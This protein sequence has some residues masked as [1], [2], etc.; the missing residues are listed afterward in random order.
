MAKKG[1]DRKI[2][3]GKSKK[4]SILGLVLPRFDDMFR[5]FY[6]S[7]V[8]RGVCNAA[9][10]AGVDIL[11]HLTKKI[12]SERSITTHFENISSCNGVI[13]ADIK[14]NEKLLNKTI[15]SGIP[16]VVINH[17][18][19]NLKAGCVAINNKAGAVNAVDYMLSLGHQ[20]I[21][22]ITGDLDIQAGRD[23]LEGYKESLNKHSIKIDK[24]L[25][26]ESDF[27]PVK[28]REKTAELIRS[29][30][31]PTAIF[32]GS[33]EIACEVVRTLKRSK[34]KVPHDISVVGF[35]NSWFATQGP[36]ALTTVKQPLSAMGERAVR[37]LE[38]MITSGGKKGATKAILPTELVVRD[39]CV[40]PLRQQDFY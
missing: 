13:F 11:V 4:I 33:D 17:Y 29:S 16:C 25:I 26:I 19:K 7:E 40:P 10:A 24:S 34:L 14:G 6:V 38:R 20:R 12:L 8:M 32:A 9:S 1:K 21:A 22:T 27:S 31:Y 30:T 23:R 37:I 36:V 28:A 15:K 2:K 18:D 35:D 5:T 3:A 39:S